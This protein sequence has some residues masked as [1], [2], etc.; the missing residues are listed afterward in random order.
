M[1]NK[2][3]SEIVVSVVLV[4]FGVVLWLASQEISVGAAMGQ[5]GDF[6]PKLCTTVWVIISVML[7]FSNITMKNQSKETASLNLKGFLATFFLLFLYMLLLKPIGFVLTSMVYMF[8]QMLLF[9]PAEY[10]TRKNYG[11]FAIISVIVPI[12]VNALFVNVFCLILPSGI[13]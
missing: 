10:R 9:V 8:F 13:L 6:M 4:I 1:E 7:L 2:K 5:G 3:L 11:L 12:A